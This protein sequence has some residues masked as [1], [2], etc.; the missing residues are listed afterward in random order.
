MEYLMEQLAWE[1]LELM[2]VQAW[3]IWTQR[4]RVIHGGKFHDPD[5]VQQPSQDSWKPPLPSVYKLNFDA[6]V[7]SGLDRS[8]FGA[9]IR[10]D[11]GEVMAAMLAKGPS[12]FCSE[13][14]ELLAFMQAI[15]S[16]NEDE[17]LMGNVV[18]DIQQMLKGQHWGNVE[19]TR[20][21][22]NKVAHVLAQYA[23]N[24]IDD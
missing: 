13:E 22:G 15:S 23:K 18:G 3:L 8:G 6:I 21:G 14:V 7:F 5:Q 24:I 17:S 19:F 12:V 10:N 20:R 2:V 9:V 4:N 1:D 11:K 16:P